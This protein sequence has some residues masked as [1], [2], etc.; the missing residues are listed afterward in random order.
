[1]RREWR[2]E[3][4]YLLRMVRGGKTINSSNDNEVTAATKKYRSK[5]R[6]VVR[7]YTEDS[8]EVEETVCEQLKSGPIPY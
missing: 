8:Y 4:T 6:K 7:S 3:W 1:M 2:D 5:L